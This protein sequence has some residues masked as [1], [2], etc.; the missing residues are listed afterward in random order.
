MVGHT[1]SSQYHCKFIVDQFRGLGLL[2]QGW[3]QLLTIH[4]L[5]Y[6]LGTP[7]PAS[8]GTLQDLPQ[9]SPQMDHPLTFRITRLSSRRWIS[10]I[11]SI[12]F[13]HLYIP[14]SSSPVPRSFR[15]RQFLDYIRKLAFVSSLIPM[16]IDILVAD[17]W[18]RYDHRTSTGK[19]HQWTS[20]SHT[21]PPLLHSELRTVLHLGRPCRWLIPT[22]RLVIRPCERDQTHRRRSRCFSEKVSMIGFEHGPFSHF[23]V[24]YIYHTHRRSETEA[25]EER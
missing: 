14:A 2:T 1:S 25:K 12:S 4:W 19:N 7:H 11:S 20:P 22:P 16:L 13:I 15:F 10:P 9:A 18:F 21:A 23:C 24:S 17:S 5:W 8:P 3:I 6:L